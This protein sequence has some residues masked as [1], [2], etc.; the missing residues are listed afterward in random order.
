MFLNFL[1]LI[2][3]STNL[4]LVLNK[5][6][7]NCKTKSFNFLQK[8]EILEI[9]IEAS[10]NI[11]VMIITD[12][13]I[14]IFLHLE[15]SEQPI[16]IELKDYIDINLQ[17]EYR[18]FTTIFNI[19]K[20]KS[21]S[22][23][24]VIFNSPV[25]KLLNFFNIYLDNIKNM[26][27]IINPYYISNFTDCIKSKINGISMEE[28][29]MIQYQLNIYSKVLIISKKMIHFNLHNFYSNLIITKNN[30]ILHNIN[31]DFIDNFKKK[32]LLCKEFLLHNL[33][34]CFSFLYYDTIKET[35]EKIFS[36]QQII[37]NEKISLQE[38]KNVFLK[39][40]EFRF[41]KNGIYAN[42]ILVKN[43]NIIFLKEFSIICNNVFY[44]DYKILFYIFN[45]TRNTKVFNEIMERMIN[46]KQE[47]EFL[48]IMS[49]LNSMGFINDSI[50]KKYILNNKD[51]FDYVNVKNLINNIKSEINNFIN[52]DIYKFFVLIYYMKFISLINKNND[53]T[54]GEIKN[55]FDVLFKNKNLSQILFNGLSL[56]NRHLKHTY[57]RE[58]IVNQLFNNK[59]FYLVKN[60]LFYKDIF[61]ENKK[62]IFLKMHKIMEKEILEMYN[63]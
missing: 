41:S 14:K 44:S 15:N 13:K 3:S 6:K 33:D 55:K 56:T 38:E 49:L 22:V 2:I 43:S 54:I 36:K 16:I 60:M 10:K 37:N 53:P 46:Q 8:S 28:N 17:I 40:F 29:I 5:E 50:F 52:D 48:I 31:K 18:L 21:E 61:S 42:K 23:L 1:Q 7:L 24:N 47:P 34:F 63:F 25:P 39:N 4:S 27:I 57:G 35:N 32:L 62:E 59:L 9:S 12:F 26:A 51:V 45:G 30:E 11:H 19:F 58:L 20:H